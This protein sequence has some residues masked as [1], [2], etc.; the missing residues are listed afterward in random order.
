MN[1]YWSDRTR[2]LFDWIH[3]YTSRDAV[4][5]RTESNILGLRFDWNW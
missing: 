2:V 4:F 3:P 1:W 5:G